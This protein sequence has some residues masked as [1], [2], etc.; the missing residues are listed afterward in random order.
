MSDADVHARIAAIVPEAVNQALT[1]EQRIM[2]LRRWLTGFVMLG[3]Q[4]TS[5]GIDHNQASLG[6]M[7]T[8]AQDRR[9]GFLCGAVAVMAQRV[10]RAFGFEAVTVNFGFPE[11]AATHV[12]TLAKIR[13]GNGEIWSVQGAYFNAILRDRNG[14]LLDFFRFLE[15]LSTGRRDEVV[16]AKAG[17][18]R[19]LMAYDRRQDIENVS[20]H[21]ELQPE[22]VE[23]TANFDL[24]CVT[25]G[26]ENVLR[27]IPA[28]GTSLK[29]AL[30][31]DDPLFLF[32]FPIS[33][34][35]EAAAEKIAQAAVAARARLLTR[36][37]P[38]SRN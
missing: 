4:Y 5:S 35:G 27:G 16:I 2:A 18:E 22:L 34:S 29:Q 31:T 9:A 20:A 36:L 37:S 12:T 7:M 19:H 10:Y 38:V 13:T 32:L 33:T 1:D 14:D 28:Y 17:D 6:E 8:I 23:R 26:M 25:W 11:T 21:F 15:L 3:D 24:Y 30:G